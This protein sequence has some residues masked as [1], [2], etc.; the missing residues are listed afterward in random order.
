MESKNIQECEVLDTLINCFG[1]CGGAYKIREISEEG[2]CFI[3]DVHQ[4]IEQD[5][6]EYEDDFYARFFQRA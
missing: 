2:L 1:N 6:Q 5:N 3:C 4:A